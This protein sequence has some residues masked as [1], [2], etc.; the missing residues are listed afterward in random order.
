MGT[1]ETA[2]DLEALFEQVGAESARDRA[3]APAAGA[4]AEPAVA[5]AVTSDPQ[6]VF[7]RV[8]A[9]TRSLHDA[10]REL[11]YAKDIEQSLQS[12]PDARSRLD[13]IATLT[14]QAAERVLGSVEKAQAEQGALQEAADGVGKRWDKVLGAEM[15]V[16]E[17]E[18]LLRD[19]RAF[20]AAMP[21]RSERINACLLD[22]MMAQDFHDLTGQIIQRVGMLAQR[23]EEQLVKL[24]LDTAPRDQRTVLAD[25]WLSGPAIHAGP[26]VVAN[27]AQVDQ[28]LESLGF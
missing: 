20:F 3:S 9:I 23:L 14:G 1:A 21:E 18:Q 10:L 11:G 16:E 4:A 27:Q 22:I 28:L 13:R 8:G 26:G 19:T 6:E 25:E 24:L 15:P 17:V 2:E 5:S 7:H 12:L